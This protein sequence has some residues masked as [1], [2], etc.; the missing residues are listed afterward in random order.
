MKLTIDACSFLAVSCEDRV[1]RLIQRFNRAIIFARF[2]VG[3]P[4]SNKPQKRADRAGSLLQQGNGLV[5]ASIAS[6]HFSAS[7]HPTADGGANESEFFVVLV[8]PVRFPGMNSA[9]SS[10]LLRANVIESL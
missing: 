10:L 7:T 1:Q 5:R 9:L 8:Q 6:K 4:S 2:R 3:Y